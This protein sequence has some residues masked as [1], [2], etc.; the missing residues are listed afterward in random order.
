MIVGK[1]LKDGF[2]TQKLDYPIALGIH[3]L[4]NEEEIYRRIGITAEERKRIY[5]SVNFYNHQED[6]PDSLRSTGPISSS[7]IREI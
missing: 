6:N 5:Q 3:R 4:L 7:A 2:L 1:W